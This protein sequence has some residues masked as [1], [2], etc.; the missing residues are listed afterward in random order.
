MATT[1]TGQQ[2]ADEGLTGWAHLFRALQTRVP[3]GD[4]TTG[5]SL[6]D[7]IA[8]AAEAADHHPDLDLRYS[9]LDVRLTSHDSG[10][11]TRRDVRLART[12]TA[13]VAEAG[14]AQET[15][16]LSALE[17]GLDT[18]AA[19]GIH[20]FWAAVLATQPEAADGPEQVVDR[21]GALPTVWFQASG[22]EPDRQ[23]WHPD[24][25]VTPEQVQPRIDAAVAAG[26]RLVSD[27]S[28]PAFWV[29]ADA[30]GNRVCLCTWQSR[31]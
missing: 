26:G 24:V 3:T 8:A 6:L 11:V 28:A 22:A 16:S 1:L 21:H 27:E 12:I 15:A 29:L 18:P 5:L 30:D 31:D 23:R 2:I 17:L 4:F 14:L 10:G 7:A 19:E 25:W 13:L 9:R 20:D